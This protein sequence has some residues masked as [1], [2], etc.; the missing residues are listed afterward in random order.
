MAL[1]NSQKSGTS[2]QLDWPQDDTSSFFALAP[3]F[4]REILFRNREI[5]PFLLGHMWPWESHLL[6]GG[7]SLHD[8][9]LAGPLRDSHTVGVCPQPVAGAVTQP[10]R[11][12]YLSHEEP[13]RD[14]CQLVEMSPKLKAVS[15]KFLC[16]LLSVLTNTSLGKSFLF[17]QLQQIS[18]LGS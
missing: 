10:P 16:H 8:I 11:C 14:N 15:M 4:Q 6:C 18:N 17:S 12:A 9:K 13:P 3:K 5:E 2:S 1:N 7:Y